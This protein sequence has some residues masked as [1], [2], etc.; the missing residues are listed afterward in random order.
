MGY[1]HAALFSRKK[2][3]FQDMPHRTG[4]GKSLEI[5]ARATLSDLKSLRQGSSQEGEVLMVN[6]GVEKAPKVLQVQQGRGTRDQ[7]ACLRRRRPKGRQ[8]EASKEG[9][10]Q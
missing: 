2:F 3:K 10:R 7:R 9:K 5:L 4:R 1:D 8:E 6:I